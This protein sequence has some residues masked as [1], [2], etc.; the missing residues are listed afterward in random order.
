MKLK[1]QNILAEI[2]KRQDYSLDS[3]E[4]NS[5]PEIATRPLSA[6]DWQEFKRKFILEY[7]GEPVQSS[8]MTHSEFMHYIKTSGGR[9]NDEYSS[10]RKLREIIERI[11]RET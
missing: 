5:K 2:R 9:E 8:G 3:T 7:G 6:D 1:I 10:S 11:D 4:E